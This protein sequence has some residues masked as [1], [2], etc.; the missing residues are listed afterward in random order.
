MISVEEAQRLILTPLTPVGGEMAVLTDALGRVLADDVAARATHP[1]ADVSAM[2]GWALR[3]QDAQG[4]GATL[5]VIGESAAG[6]AFAG[7]VGP[8]QA[9]RIFTGAHMPMGADSVVMQEDCKAEGGRVT[10]AIAALPGSHVRPKGLDFATGRV[11]LTAGRRLTSRDIGLL[12]AMNV[13]WVRVRR[14]PRI[15][16][17]SSGDELALPGEPLPEGGIPASNGLALAAFCKVLGAEPVDLGIAPDDALGLQRLAKGAAGA[18]L[19]VTSGGASVGDHDLVKSALGDVGL[20]VGFHKVAMRPGKPLLFGQMNGAPLLGLPGNPVSALVTAQLF[21]GP[22]LRA[23]LG[24]TPVIEPP[25]SARLASPLPANDRRQDYLR[26]KLE[27]GQDGSWTA[28]PFDRQDSAMMAALAKADGLII[29]PPMSP[30]AKPGDLV[31]V[32]PLGGGGMES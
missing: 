16:I 22:A 25:L 5:S 29:R 6:H 12:A 1:P 10:L 19:V 32:L 23:L 24:Q 4:P 26:A 7:Q 14:K 9:V 20:Q 21:L 31:P 28:T 11:L 13:P 8:G 2:D 3:A 18:D 15:A 17:L 30:I 27:R